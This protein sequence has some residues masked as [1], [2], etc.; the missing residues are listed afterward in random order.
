ML[1]DKIGCSLGSDELEDDAI[2]LLR[3]YYECTFRFCCN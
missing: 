3:Y 1:Y 2:L